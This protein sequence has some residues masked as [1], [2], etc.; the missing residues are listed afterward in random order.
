[1]GVFRGVGGTRLVP[2]S[3]ATASESTVR[4]TVTVIPKYHGIR[5]GG[6]LDSRAV[7]GHGTRRVRAPLPPS[8]AASGLR[9][10]RLQTLEGRQEFKFPVEANLEGICLIYNINPDNCCQ[11]Y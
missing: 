11:I 8:G 10:G 9:R 4:V 1:M 5:V 7:G 6:I 3:T 2:E